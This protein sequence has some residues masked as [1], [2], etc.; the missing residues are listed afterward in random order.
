M[1]RL[2]GKDYSRGELLERVGQIAQVAGLREYRIQGGPADGVHAVDVYTGSGLRFTVLPG[3]G[4]D[5]SHAS[6][7]GVP[8]GWISPSGEASAF[9]YEPQGLG[10]L[11][12]FAGGLLTTCGFTHTGQPVREGG[13]DYGLHGRASTLIASNVVA[14]GEWQGRAYRLRVKG[15]AREAALFNEQI[16]LVRVISADLGASKLTIE[17]SVTNVGYRRTPHMIL[18]HINL[19]FPLLG[20][21][22]ELVSPTLAFTP[23]DA[24]AAD[25]AEGP[26]RFSE[27]AAGYD[28]KVY[29]HEVQADSKGMVHVALVNSGLST[30]PLGLSISY[31]Q[32]ELTHFNQWKMLGKGEYVLGIEPANAG[33]EGRVAERKAGNL[34]YLE[35]GESR[36]YLVEIGVLDGAAEIGRFR[37]KVESILAK[38]PPA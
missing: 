3:R 24:A 12:T 1:P 28:E 17:D 8:L 13:K 34:K 23:R 30:G 14:E 29:G 7:G 36:R 10:W 38:R 26:F 19:G 31:R 6:Y 18:Y 27:P 5:I 15:R 2:F 37:A 16:E 22:A 20:P 25:L 9:A 33:V 21:E 4:L 35:P 11:R 32:A